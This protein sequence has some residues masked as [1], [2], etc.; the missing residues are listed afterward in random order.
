MRYTRILFA[1]VGLL[2]LSL[3]AARGGGEGLINAVAYKPLPASAALGV[4]P[5]DNSEENLAL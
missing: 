4:R 5:L 3:G 2:V 1:A